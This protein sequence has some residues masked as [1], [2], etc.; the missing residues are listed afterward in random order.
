MSNRGPLAANEQEVTIANG[1]AVSTE[2]AIESRPTGFV[3]EINGWTS[4]DI[5][6][7]VYSP[8]LEAWLPV[9]YDGSA[10]T[11]TGISTSAGG[12]Y[13][14]PVGAWFAGAYERGRLRSS[15][16]QGAARTLVVRGV[17]G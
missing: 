14:V 2:F 15:N 5:T 17:A 13:G 16:N 9:Y 7:E 1:E 8:T 6:L 10:V 11:V 4:A 3:I 12:A